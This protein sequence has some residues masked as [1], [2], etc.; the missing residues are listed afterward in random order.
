MMFANAGLEE[1]LFEMIRRQGKGI[2]MGR[3]PSVSLS[4]NHAQ[5]IATW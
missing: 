1:E 2:P 3:Q 4:N 5:Y